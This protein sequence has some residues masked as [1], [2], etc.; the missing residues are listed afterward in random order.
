MRYRY[1]HTVHGRV[2][3]ATTSGTV[4]TP[5][6]KPCRFRHH[7][8]APDHCT[9]EEW[10]ALCG[11]HGLVICVTDDIAPHVHDIPN[12]SSELVHWLRFDKKL[13]GFEIILGS[14]YLPHERSKYNEDGIYEDIAEDVMYLNA[15]CDDPLMILTGDYN[16][17]TGV[18]DD[19]ITIENAVAECT[20]INVNDESLYRSK[21]NLSDKGIEVY[22]A[23]H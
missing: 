12:T 21:H 19:C 17:R 14:L 3:S 10:H 6:F 7:I 23:L 15:H 5:G 9:H 20:G 16:A 2:W 8:I 13:L 11:I 18:L 4:S 22:K 1:Q